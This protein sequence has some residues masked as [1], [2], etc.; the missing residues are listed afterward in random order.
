MS[1]EEAIKEVSGIVKSGRKLRSHPRLYYQGKPIVDVYNARSYNLILQRLTI[2]KDWTLEQAI[3]K[4]KL[5]KKDGADT[6]T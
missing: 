5:F 1:V 4:G 2:H 3:A 6:Q